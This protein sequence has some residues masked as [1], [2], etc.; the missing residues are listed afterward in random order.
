MGQ[1]IHP[2]GFRVGIT[3]DWH[4]TWFAGQKEYASLV[5]EDINIRQAID[6][7]YEDAGISKV[8]IERDS[9][10]VAVTI[11]TARPGIVIGR[12]GQRVDELR[13]HLETLTGN[14]RAKLNVK[15]VRQAELDAY[16]VA[17]NV[18]D[19]LERRIAFRRAIRQAVMRT[20]QAGAEGIK[21]TCSGRLAGADIARAEKAMEGRVP[22]H[23]L[24]ADIDYGLAEAQTEFGVI[25]VKVWICR[26]EIMNPTIIG[27]NSTGSEELVASTEVEED[28]VAPIQ[29]MVTAQEDSQATPVGQNETESADEV[30]VEVQGTEEDAST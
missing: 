20:M 6:G 26:G 12:G 3:R 17:R 10:E 27:E 22:L 25:G 16:L 2:N 8:D 19:Q 30:A 4:A 23:T 15:E 5:T 29:V 1:K 7:M 13:K 9:N 18:A 11:H 28:E 14:R 24:R 21:I